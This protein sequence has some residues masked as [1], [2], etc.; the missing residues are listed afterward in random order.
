MQLAGLFL[1]VN[2]LWL[3][4]GTAMGL[5]VHGF[6]AGRDGSSGVHV[7]LVSAGAV[8][9]LVLWLLPVAIVS[10]P[11]VDKEAGEADGAKNE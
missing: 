3:A 4:S 10:S 7:A 1:L 6:V 8:G 9:F 2:V 5:G 11:P